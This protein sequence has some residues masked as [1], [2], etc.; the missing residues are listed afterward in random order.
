MVPPE[1]DL[2]RDALRKRLCDSEL[3]RSFLIEILLEADKYLAN[4]VRSPKVSHS[5]RERVVVLEA[6]QWRELGLVKLFDAL[7][8][9]VR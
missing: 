2:W 9:I 3:R 5:I 4:L 6:Q 1:F 7:G 8:D